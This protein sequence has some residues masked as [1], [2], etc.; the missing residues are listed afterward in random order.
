MFIA[1]LDD[2]LDLLEFERDLER[3]RAELGTALARIEARTGLRLVAP[4]VAP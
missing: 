1:V 2:A 4:E 3:Q